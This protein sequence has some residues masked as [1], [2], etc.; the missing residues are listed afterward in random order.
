MIADNE[1]P[2]R[3]K[4]IGIAVLSSVLVFTVIGL[5][6]LAIPVTSHC[7]GEVSSETET[8]KAHPVMVVVWPWF[9]QHQVFGI[10]V[11]P[12]RYQTCRRY[13]G[14]ISALNFKDEFV[15]DWQPNIHRVEDVVAEPGSYLVRGYIPTRIALWFFITGQTGELRSLCNWTLELRERSQYFW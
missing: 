10:S 13:S 7:L 14:T 2:G 1:M 12:I 15:P 3:Y 4:K 8:Y 6:L 5:W 11:V 9:G